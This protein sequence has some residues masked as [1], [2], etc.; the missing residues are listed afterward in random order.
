MSSA[1]RLAS[2]R[3]VLP[4]DWFEFLGLTE[5]EHRYSDQFTT[6]AKELLAS[7]YLIEVPITLTNWVGRP[8]SRWPKALQDR[9]AF[10]CGRVES[11][12][13]YITCRPQY[14]PLWKAAD[15]GK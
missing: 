3:D 11:N 8:S 9:S 6:A 1:R 7:G 12:L 10:V 14:A 13:V 15:E 2:A 4:Y 5:S